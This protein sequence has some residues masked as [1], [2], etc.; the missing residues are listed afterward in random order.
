MH[1]KKKI[2]QIIFSDWNTKSLI[3][4]YINGSQGNWISNINLHKL[5]TTNNSIYIDSVL[6]AFVLSLIL[7]FKYEFN[8]F[9]LFIIDTANH[10]IYN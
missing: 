2:Q 4:I 7:Y 3:K 8:C 9:L 1:R 5:Y 10:E 6:A